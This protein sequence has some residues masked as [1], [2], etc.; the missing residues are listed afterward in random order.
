MHLEIAAYGQRPILFSRG[1]D[2]NAAMSILFLAGQPPYSPDSNL[3][4]LSAAALR[5]QV[6]IAWGLIDTIELHNR[7]ISVL[8]EPLSTLDEEKPFAPRSRLL[9]NDFDT[10][11]VLSLGRRKTFLDK[12]QL[13]NLVPQN[14]L[15]NNCHALMHLNSKY[16]LAALPDSIQ[17]T[18]RLA[19]ANP[20]SIKG[21]L[22]SHDQWIM[23]PAAGSQGRG[24]YQLS[25]NDANV[26]SILNHEMSPDLSAFQLLEAR[27]QQIDQGEKRILIANGI[28]IGAYLRRAHHEHRTNLA[29]GA[30]AETT[31]LTQAEQVL[32]DVLARHCETQ[33]ARFVGIDLVYPYVIE[34]NVINPG[35][36]GTLIQLGEGD[37]SDK[38][39]SALYPPVLEF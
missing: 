26:Q 9:L 39:I 20:E 23:K 10:I 3:I 22:N 34:I 35:G 18:E 30:S 27:V 7:I 17:Q 11:W 19:S 12:L 6:D 8:G 14:R 37:L 33:G 4:R 15:V 31:T 5:A 1:I 28:V 24:V 13:L 36:I 29:V 16:G 21:A 38:I 25:G 2:H 32:C